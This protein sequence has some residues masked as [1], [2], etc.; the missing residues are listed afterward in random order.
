MENFKFQLQGPSPEVC[1]WYLFGRSAYKILFGLLQIKTWVRVVDFPV[2]IFHGQIFQVGVLQNVFD[3]R[4][5]LF[6]LRRKNNRL[7]HAR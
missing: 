5:Q 7:H 4:H 6:V 2:E 1:G 3:G